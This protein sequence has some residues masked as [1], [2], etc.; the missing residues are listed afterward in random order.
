M[1]TTCPNNISLTEHEFVTGEVQH[2]AQLNS[3]SP[4]PEAKQNTLVGVRR[5]FGVYIDNDKTHNV[6]PYL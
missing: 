1:V 5:G 6:I 4:E 3:G 2:G